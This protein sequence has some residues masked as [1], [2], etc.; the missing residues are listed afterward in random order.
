[1]ASGSV[2]TI[3]KQYSNGKYCSSAEG[4]LTLDVP[5]GKYLINVHAKTQS[6]GK[7]ITVSI[8]GAEAADN[9]YGCFIT[10]TNGA[11]RV[12]SYTIACEKTYSSANT[13]TLS[14]SDNWYRMY[15]S[16]LRVG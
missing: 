16:A 15:I 5:A 2:N 3:G 1:M 8:D 11:S 7:T 4:T 13:I 14:Y 9:A 6:S 10:P 12:L